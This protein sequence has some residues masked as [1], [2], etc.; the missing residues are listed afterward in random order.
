MGSSQVIPWYY[1]YFFGGL[2]PVRES[3]QSQARLKLKTN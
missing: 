1:Y 2:E 3:I